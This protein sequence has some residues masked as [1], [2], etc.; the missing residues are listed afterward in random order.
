MASDLFTAVATGHTAAYSASVSGSA[1]SVSTTGDSVT[2]DAK[3]AGMATVTVTASA[4][5]ASSARPSQTV[6]DIAE[7]A[8]D[9]MVVD[10]AL[11]VM[12]EMPDGVMG[13]NLVEGES[14]DIKAVANRAVSE[15]T[16]VMIMCVTARRATPART[17]TQ[18]IRP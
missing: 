15:D 9:V 6:D 18:S 5:P 2:V 8:F 1:V 7:V 3:S 10:K 16:E 11:V 17:T 12:L 14:Y 4:K 13:G